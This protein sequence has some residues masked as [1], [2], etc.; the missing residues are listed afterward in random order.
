MTEERDEVWRIGDFELDPHRRELRRGAEVVALRSRPLELLCAFA[1]FPNRL[2][3]KDELL[4][5]AWP[6]VIVEEN[7]LQVQVSVL[8]K[9][10]GSQSIVTVSGKG[11]S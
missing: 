9:L 3:S 2:Q 5:R 8:R 7:N 1:E 10:L 4:S 6:G 11:Y